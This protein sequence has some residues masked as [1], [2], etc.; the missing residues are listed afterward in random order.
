MS[1]IAST[2][3]SRRPVA[4][5]ACLSCREKKIKCD[6]E[7]HTAARLADGAAALLTTLC[8]NCKFLG[9]ECVFVRSM[10]GGRRKKRQ[11]TLE[12]GEVDRKTQKPM[13]LPHSAMTHTSSS[14]GRTGHRQYSASHSQSSANGVHV[15]LPDP[16]AVRQDLNGY[17][18]FD[19][20]LKR[21][22][23]PTL[24]YA[25]N[26]YVMDQSKY[27]SSS[28]DPDAMDYYDY[29]YGRG[30]PMP[31]PHDAGHPPP[32]PFG[33][34]EGGMRRYY[35]H[36]YGCGPPHHR[37]GMRHGGRHGPPPPP[38][39][40]YGPP[41]FHGYLYP[42][43]PMPQPPQQ[44]P[45]QPP[46][47]PLPPL[48]L[49][50]QPLRASSTPLQP[51]SLSGA[52][53]PCPPA[54][55]AYALPGLRAPLL[56]PLDRADYSMDY[57]QRRQEDTPPE[58]LPLH[59]LPYPKAPSLVAPS[60]TPRSMR[61]PHSSPRPAATT[62]SAALTVPSED[63]AGASPAASP[64]AYAAAPNPT[65]PHAAPMASSADA[66]LARYDLPPESTVSYL[67]DLYYHY[68]QPFHQ[69]LPKKLIFLKYYPYDSNASIYHALISTVA[70]YNS[71]VSTNEEVW[72]DRF[73]KHCDDLGTLQMLLGYILILKTLKC[74][75]TYTHGKEL[76]C[77]IWSI[78]KHNRLHLSCQQV[79][80]QEYRT[81]FELS[82]TRQLYE[83][84]MLVR[85]MWDFYICRVLLFRLKLGHPYNKL[86][87]M[88]TQS[89]EMYREVESTRYAECVELPVS[90]ETY[91]R[92]IKG[93]NFGERLQWADVHVLLN[94]VAEAPVDAAYNGFTD[95]VL[96]VLAAHLMENAAD[97][98]SRN[99]LLKTN[100]VKLE[101]LIERLERLVARNRLF[102]LT[103]DTK[104]HINVTNVALSLILKGIKM[105]LNLLFVE[106]I[107]VFKPYQKESDNRADFLPLIND[108]KLL[109]LPDLQ[110]LSQLVASHS[111]FQ[112]K[113]LTTLT[114][115]SLEVIKLIELGEGLV[116][117]NY[118]FNPN[119][120]FE[121]QKTYQ[122]RMGIAGEL[123]ASLT[124]P[125]FEED[126]TP[127]VYV[128]TV[129]EQP[130][131]WLQYPDFSMMVMGA[132]MGNLGSLIIISE[133]VRFEAAPAQPGDP[134]Y[135]NAVLRLPEATEEIVVERI[136]L[137]NDC[138][139][140]QLLHEFKSNYLLEKFSTCTNYIKSRARFSDAVVK[141]LSIKSERIM[142]YL[143]EFLSTRH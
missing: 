14:D 89:R 59:P 20:G 137:R 16:N 102:H 113:C 115:A 30:P 37:R 50:P 1:S 9:I 122:V 90:N 96:L 63:K 47:L 127:K 125:W 48:Q 75:H 60:T 81:N 133:Y 117:E 27:G 44:P 34:V 46:P 140:Q 25:L 45:Q 83:R 116:P 23:S 8:S 24:S 57:Y 134:I 130:D 6:G 51:S 91:A 61:S 100:L 78:I 107:I 28:H 131:A 11:A 68:N 143:E 92:G 111:M 70:K 13:S 118:T 64:R 66:M 142:H 108:I 2:S 10:R 5:R 94:K 58:R 35:R 87:V 41:P 79:L 88:E 80:A 103:K 139:L 19:L 55:P 129:P 7:P 128:P 49:P 3:S 76:N 17:S 110:V 109:L 99:G 121:N 40:P 136:E 85:L 65:A 119:P 101:S 95:S 93:L 29:R 42:P 98:V 105:V 15:P 33:H 74:S 106:E 18:N 97:T 54:V 114:S 141:D 71:Q 84:E 52:G 104:M 53:P 77:K 67:L 123:A 72:I 4:R 39:P 31:M 22:P 62:A 21:P 56:P 138:V 82:S 32:P 86:S 26:S 12:D 36:L 112:W 124:K 135:V 69:L 73:H 126:L 120:S 38:M 43:P 132:L